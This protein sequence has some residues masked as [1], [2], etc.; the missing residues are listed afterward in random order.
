MF[1][2]DKNLRREI[3]SKATKPSHLFRTKALT[4]PSGQV[5]SYLNG[6][7]YLNGVFQ[8]KKSF[9]HFKWGK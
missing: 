4:A 5:P 3:G 8:K 9:A 1:K 2:I 6:I 7:C